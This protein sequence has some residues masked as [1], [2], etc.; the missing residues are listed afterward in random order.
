MGIENLPSV[1]FFGVAHGFNNGFMYLGH[2]TC[3]DFTDD[4]HDGGWVR[5]FPMRDALFVRKYES[6]CVFVERFH[7]EI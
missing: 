3:D 7:F 5:G 1:S 2:V 4:E 6:C